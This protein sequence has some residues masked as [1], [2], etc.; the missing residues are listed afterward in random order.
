MASAP[1]TGAFP[2]DMDLDAGYTFAWDA[3]DA[4]T[5]A[6]V[7]NVTVSLAT[8]QADNLGSLAALDVGPFMVVPGPAA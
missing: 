1:V 6:T 8:I 5:G 3:V 7:A 2:P 4:A